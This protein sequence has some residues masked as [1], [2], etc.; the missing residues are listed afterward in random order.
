MLEIN[1]DIAPNDMDVGINK[2]CMSSVK[3]SN[4]TAMEN[5]KMQNLIFLVLQNLDQAGVIKG[6]ALLLQGENPII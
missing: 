2:V 3:Q 5:P 4:L 6:N 1:G